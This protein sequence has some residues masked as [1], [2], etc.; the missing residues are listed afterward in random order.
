M[1]NLSV[2]YYKG[3]KSKLETEKKSEGDGNW[4]GK[5]WCRRGVQGK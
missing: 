3:M 4:M 2:S 5:S 1:K